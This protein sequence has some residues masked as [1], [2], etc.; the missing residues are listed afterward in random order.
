MNQPLNQHPQGFYLGTQYQ[1]APKLV[2]SH[3]AEQYF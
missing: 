3:K 1:I 2:R